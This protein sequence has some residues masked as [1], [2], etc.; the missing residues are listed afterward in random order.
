MF[1]GLDTRS[2]LFILYMNTY[3]RFFFFRAK[4][5]FS[6]IIKLKSYNISHIISI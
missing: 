6:H 1:S 2:C 5:G 4:Y 3:N